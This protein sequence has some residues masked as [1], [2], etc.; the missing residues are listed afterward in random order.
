MS[1]A[2]EFCALVEEAK[3]QHGTTKFGPAKQAMD[4]FVWQ[5]TGFI[6]R[7]LRMQASIDDPRVKSLVRG[8]ALRLA[9]TPHTG[10]EEQDTATYNVILSDALAGFLGAVK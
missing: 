2:S 4:T 1:K 8:Y 6:A 9:Q 5:N 7:G 3:S 10:D